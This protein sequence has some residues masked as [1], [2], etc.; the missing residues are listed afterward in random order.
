MASTKTVGPK[1]EKARLDWAAIA[2]NFLNAAFA[3]AS[4]IQALV[5]AGV[6]SMMI[7][8]YA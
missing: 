5:K 4:A 6:Q 3:L 1:I 7:K 2:L 8:T